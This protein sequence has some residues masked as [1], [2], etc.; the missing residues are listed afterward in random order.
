MD[1]R[2]RT[3]EGKAIVSH[4]KHSDET[5]Q[6]TASP[7]QPKRSR[8]SEQRKTVLIIGAGVAGLSAAKTL[9]ELDGTGYCVFRSGCFLGPDSCF[10]TNSILVRVLEGRSRI[11]GRVSTVELGELHFFCLL[12]WFAVRLFGDANLPSKAISQDLASI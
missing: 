12:S 5:G 8:H 10:A 3:K 11:G 1:L 7:P 6:L 4:S 2:P 9:R